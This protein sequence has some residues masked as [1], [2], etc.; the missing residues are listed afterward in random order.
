MY[1]AIP[2]LHVL[3]YH[4]GAANRDRGGRQ[5][6]RQGGPLH[7]LHARPVL[8]HT[9]PKPAQTQ[10]ELQHVGEVR[11]REQIFTGYTERGERGICGREKRERAWV[12]EAL[13]QIGLHERSG[14][15]GHILVAADSFCDR[16]DD[17]LIVIV[18]PP[19]GVGTPHHVPV[20]GTQP[21]FPLN[22]RHIGV[23][24][25]IIEAAAVRYLQA[26]LR[27]DAW[28]AHL[29]HGQVVP[30]GD[31]H[32]H[33]GADEAIDGRRFVLALTTTSPVLPRRIIVALRAMSK[34]RQ[35]N[36]GI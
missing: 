24:R 7:G 17:A 11:P 15:D 28:V 33:K 35:K 13:P 34:H 30:S 19:L 21:A 20:R 14:Q 1:Q 36:R 12:V 27:A 32:A 4:G 29:R 18:E 5:V 9:A 6:H 26:L 23:A 2:A 31:P 8:Q 3:S 16:W 25:A 22:A 10:V